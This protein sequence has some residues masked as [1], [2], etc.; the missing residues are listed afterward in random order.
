MCTH[1]WLIITKP[2]THYA[3][4]KTTAEKKSIFLFTKQTMNIFHSIY[5]MKHILSSEPQSRWFACACTSMLIAYLQLL[6][7][8]FL[9][10]PRFFVS[11]PL[12][13]YVFYKDIYF[14]ARFRSEHVCI[15]RR[16]KQHTATRKWSTDVNE[17]KKPRN[18]GFCSD[19]AQVS[20]LFFDEWII[21]IWLFWVL[22]MTSLC[23]I[24]GVFACLQ[25]L[26]INLC[27]RF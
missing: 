23:V 27:L 22:L 6:Y 18:M 25:S 3:S 4:H 26:P 21:G 9:L 10:L 12:E 1:K 2:Q 8:F 17:L 14:C 20:G 15:L 11:S 5:W 24:L 7:G 16:K 19:F 13:F